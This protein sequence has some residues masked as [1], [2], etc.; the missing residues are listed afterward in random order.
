MRALSGA[1]FISNNK[2]IG[3]IIVGHFNMSEFWS[4]VLKE[5][6]TFSIFFLLI[7]ILLHYAGIE[8]SP[9]IIGKSAVLLPF[10]LTGI[11]KYLSNK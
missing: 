10:A 11:K 6:T 2:T 9:E 3:K 5:G 4:F 7:L 8:L 1:L